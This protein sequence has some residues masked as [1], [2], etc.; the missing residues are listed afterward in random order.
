MVV[1]VVLV[2]GVLEADVADVLDVV[3]VGVDVD[4]ELEASRRAA[5]Q[6]AWH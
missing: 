5:L 6:N 2:V 1:V 3:V 4:A